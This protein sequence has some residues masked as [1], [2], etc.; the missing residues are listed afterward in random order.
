MQAQSHRPIMDPADSP[1]VSVVAPAFN[2]QECLAAFV[3]RVDAVM[4]RSGSP[5]EII[6]VND[7]SSDRTLD[8][9][10][11]LT[12]RFTQLRVVNLSRNFGHEMAS[13]AG[14]SVARGDVVILIDADLQD[15]PEVID[16]LLEKWRQGFHVVYAQRRRRPGENFWKRSTSWLFYRLMR[17]ATGLE[18]PTE[19]GDFRLMDRKVVE[20]F[21]RMSE[22]HRFV[23]G[24]VAWL[25]FRQT[26][27]MFDREPRFA[28]E[29]KYNFKKL[30]HLAV[31]SVVGFTTKP[32]RLATRIGVGM[33]FLSAL[34][35]FYILVQKLF[36]ELKNLAPWLSV[37]RAY[38]GYALL[39]CALFFIGGVQCLL[40][41][42]LG[43][44]LGRLY[45]QAQGRP[46]FVIEGVYD[47]STVDKRG[48]VDAPALE[49]PPSVALD[50]LSA[51]R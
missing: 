11:G 35:F 20:A 49:R 38:E 34:G 30:V 29:T 16:E 3:E 25:G 46:L 24:M 14:L 17:W 37:D 7:G 45:E 36:P 19:T 13:S 6:V 43:E 4:R 50:P 51:P 10:L 21:N 40:I 5:Y 33:F 32:L 42:V 12:A 2:E 41:G 31:E 18:L 1:F 47:A 48:P 27:V 23:R 28:G 8:V 15:P 22:R 9:G 44:Y 26:G 39:M